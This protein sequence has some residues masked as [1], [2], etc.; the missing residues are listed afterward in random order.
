MFPRVGRYDRSERI[1]VVHAQSAAIANRAKESRNLFLNS[2]TTFREM[3]QAE[4]GKGIDLE[5]LIKIKEATAN[6]RHA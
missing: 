3:V 6:R 5:G 1:F 2:M 4:R